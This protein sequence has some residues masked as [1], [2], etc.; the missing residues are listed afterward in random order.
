SFDGG[1]ANPV[2]AALDGLNLGGCAHHGVNSNRSTMIHMDG[3]AD[4]DLSGLAKRLQSMRA[5]RLHQANHV[6]SGINGWKLM[7][8]RGEGLFVLH[9]LLCRTLDADR[10]L[11]NHSAKTLSESGQNS[12]RKYC[13]SEKL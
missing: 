4:R 13:R 2:E 1:D 10:N 9:P 12:K 5:R 3:R 11:F 7:I 8:M 6:R